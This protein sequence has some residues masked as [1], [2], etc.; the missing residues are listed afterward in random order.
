[1]TIQSLAEFKQTFTC[2]PVEVRLEGDGYQS[3]DCYLKPMTSRDRDA[4]EASVAG[5]DGKR[6]LDNLRA[7]LVAKCLCDENGALLCT[8]AKHENI[9]RDPRLRVRFMLALKMGMPV[10]RLVKE[11]TAAEEMHWFAFYNISPWGEEREDIRNAG[12]LQMIHNVNAKVS[13]KLDKFLLFKDPWRRHEG[14]D[15]DIL[16]VFKGMK[17]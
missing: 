4:Y 3:F 11:M 14:V 2:D 13:K 15:A 5:I 16:S 7:R 6:D 12:I 17:K 1:M 10:S 8:A 9:L